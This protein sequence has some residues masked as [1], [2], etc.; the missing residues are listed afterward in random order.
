MHVVYVQMAMYKALEARFFRLNWYL[1]LEFLEEK[2][3][4]L[5]FLEIHIF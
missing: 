5:H 3:T 4:A 1:F 2:K